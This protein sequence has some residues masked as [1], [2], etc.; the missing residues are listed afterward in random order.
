MTIAWSM[1][2]ESK[3]RREDSPSGVSIRFQV[4]EASFHLNVPWVN[5]ALVGVL[6]MAGQTIEDACGQAI[7]VESD[8]FGRSAPFRL[9]GRWRTSSLAR[10][11]CN[12]P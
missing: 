3:F 12:G 8:L 7:R 2:A 5:G 6:P 9:L 10:V 11:F 4:S 1:P